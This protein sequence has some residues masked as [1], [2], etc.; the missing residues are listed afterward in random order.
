MSIWPHIFKH[1]HEY[2]LLDQLRKRIVFIIVLYYI[3]EFTIEYI[4]GQTT[5][6]LFYYVLLLTILICLIILYLLLYTSYLKT[7]IYLSAWNDFFN[8]TIF[9]WFTGG[10]HSTDIYWYFTLILALLLFL[11]KTAGVFCT[12]GAFLNILLLYYAESQR[13]FDFQYDYLS[14]GIELRFFNTISVF[15][16]I[17]FIGVLV[18]K[19]DILEL[20]SQKQKD[21]NINLLEFELNKRLMEMEQLR[22][23]IARDFHDTI[24]NQLASIT[25]SS[26]SLIKSNFS[27]EDQLK[28]LQLIHDLSRRIYDETKDFIWSIRFQSNNIL[29]LYIYIKDFGEKYF[30]QSTI[31][32]ISSG[33]DN[34][35]EEVKISPNIT[36]DLILICK[37]AFTNALIHSK[38]T[39]IVFSIE[40]KGDKVKIVVSD[41][42]IGFEENQLH[43]MNGILNMRERSNRIDATI[44]IQSKSS[45]GTIISIILNEKSHYNRG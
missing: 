44:L 33:I 32:F 36:T 19:K 14:Y 37:E 25:H 31:D 30:E 23:S 40:L 13:W 24:G 12:I 39:Q 18:N 16:M 34:E 5:Y 27:S 10:T 15:V 42:G 2:S 28:K 11:N 3:I 7:A 4:F 6:P 43:R 22:Q 17:F 1:Y 9:I 20:S 45:R 38:A 29:E 35:F 8:T 21:D 26:G 41:N